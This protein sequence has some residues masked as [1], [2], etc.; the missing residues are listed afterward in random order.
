MSI[1]VKEQ[2][3]NSFAR[4]LILYFGTPLVATGLMTKTCIQ[5][6]ENEIFHEIY[7]APR[8]IDRNII[9]KLA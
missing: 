8:D 3:L 7:L 4:S 1:E 6:L 2:I 5:S 9:I